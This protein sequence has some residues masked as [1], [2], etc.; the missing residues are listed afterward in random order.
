MGLN[1]V[2]S[3]EGRRE[4]MQAYLL[5]ESSKC[6]CLAHMITSNKVDLNQRVRIDWRSIYHIWTLKRGVISASPQLTMGW[7][8]KGTEICGQ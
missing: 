5:S 6:T 2:A 8:I 3:K 4:W 1:R 7:E